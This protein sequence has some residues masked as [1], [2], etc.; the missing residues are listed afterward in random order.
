VSRQIGG[1]HPALQFVS[2]RL[3]NVREQA[4]HL[5]END[6]D[7]RELCDEYRMC[8]ETVARMESG[9]DNA[10]SLR[11]EYAALQLRLEAELLRYLAE[12]PDV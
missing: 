10:V 9:L 5:F 6:E 4:S 12:R 1:M 7:F 11:K 3:P 8:S 2:E